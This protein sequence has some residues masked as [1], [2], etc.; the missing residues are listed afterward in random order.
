MRYS[1]PFEKVSQRS[2]LYFNRFLPAC[3]KFIRR[4]LI[5]FA[6]RLRR[7]GLRARHLYFKNP[8]LFAFIR[9]IG[10]RVTIEGEFYSHRRY[11]SYVKTGV[12][13]HA[14]LIFRRLKFDHHRP[15][16]R[17]C[18]LAVPGVTVNV[19]NGDL[20]TARGVCRTDEPLRYAYR[21]PDNPLRHVK[22]SLK[23]I[24]VPEIIQDLPLLPGAFYWI[25][26]R[27]VEVACKHQHG[28]SGSR[29]RLGPYAFYA[30]CADRAHGCPFPASG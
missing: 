13:N 16:A 19:N 5:G 15:V 11:L 24:A 18:P 23:N 2:P 17:L 6:L 1:E 9:E 28:L 10:R 25:N 30:V 7:G 3:L 27:G 21:D 4:S 22:V 29:V 26:F 12:G 20:Y 8:Y 14:F